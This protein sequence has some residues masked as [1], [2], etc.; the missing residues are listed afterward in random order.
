MVKVSSDQRVFETVC[1]P[2]RN[3]S[4]VKYHMRVTHQNRVDVLD[5]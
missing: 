3:I 1:L 5:L 4:M 2:R